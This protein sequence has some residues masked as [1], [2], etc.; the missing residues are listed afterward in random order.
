MALCS[1]QSS[2][3][4]NLGLGVG[5]GLSSLLVLVLVPSDFHR[6]RWFSS[7]EKTMR[8]PE[9]L[10]RCRRNAHFMTSK[11]FMRTHACCAVVVRFF[12]NFP[13]IAARL[14]VRS[15]TCSLRH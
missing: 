9:I 5:I 4:K 1:H 15:S 13:T 12:V 6:V 8:T 11:E 10:R 7:L 14:F 3:S 2:L